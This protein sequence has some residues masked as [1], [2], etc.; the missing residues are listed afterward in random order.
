GR[1]REQHHLH[2]GAARRGDGRDRRRRPLP[3]VDRPDQERPG[4]R[5]G[6]RRPAPLGP[7]RHGRRRAQGRLRPAVRL[8]PGRGGLAPG[9]PLGP[10]ALADRLVRPLGQGRRDRGD[11]LPR[12]RHRDADARD[13]QAQGGE[14]ADG[15]GAQ[16]AQEAR[17]A[18]GPL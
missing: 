14:G 7:L 3:G 12:G 17:R 18:A 6:R 1:P 2:L 4:A 9:G 15:L 8:A 11:L 13:V 5:P 10:A 16:G